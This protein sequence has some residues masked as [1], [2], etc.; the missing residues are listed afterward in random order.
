VAP[1]PERPAVLFV[2]ALERYKN[3]EGLAAAWALVAT[4]VPDARLVIVGSGAQ[5]DVVDRLRAEFPDRVEHHR[6][7]EP[8][9]VARAL[10]EATVLALPSWPEGLG[11]VVIEAFARGRAVVG[12]DGGGIPDLVDDGVEG[13]LVPPFDDEALAER[14]VRILT[15]SELA[16]RLGAAAHAR[17]A[18]WETSPADLA[19][20]LRDLVERTTA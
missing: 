19:T 2:G 8:P 18:T 12:T 4:R 9:E 3:V 14:L 7:L 6:W 20:H 17:F 15:D 1:L 13:Y 11:R 10:D 16:A 5:Q